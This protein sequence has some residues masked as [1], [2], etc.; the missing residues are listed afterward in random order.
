L[1]YK[2]LD[3]RNPETHKTILNRYRV[4]K[5]I[6]DLLDQENFIEVETPILTSGT[7]E[8]ARE[9]IIPSRKFPGKFYTLPQAPQ[10]FKQM[11]MVSG[12]EKYF[13]IARCFRD[14]DSRGD[15]QAEF[16]QLDIGD[17][18]CKHV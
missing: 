4:I 1:K 11:L 15:R 13:Q 7:D 16:T 14:E 9:F 8:G 12:Y 18:I 17:G 5:T 2:F 3:H 10:Q 6:R